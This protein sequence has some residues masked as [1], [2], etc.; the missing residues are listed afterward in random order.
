MRYAKY[1]GLFSAYKA[2]LSNALSISYLE[3]LIVESRP[4]KQNVIGYPV[5]TI[6][7]FETQ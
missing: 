5:N 1:N 7:C 4:I 6:K 3:R 2:Y